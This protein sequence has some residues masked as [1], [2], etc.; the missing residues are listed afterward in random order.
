MHNQLKGILAGAYIL[1]IVLLLL[2]TCRHHR[3]NPDEVG[4]DGDIKITMFWDFPGDVDLHV[5]QPNGN[6]L[7]F[8]NMDDS[9][10]RGG[11]LDV[12]DRTGG[13]GS[14][15]N[16]YWRDPMEG[17]YRVRVVYYRADDEAPDGGPV[18][19][20]V[21]INGRSTE[22]NIELHNA[23]DDIPV[24]TFNYSRRVTATRPGQ[25]DTAQ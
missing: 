24:T 23:Q 10:N 18:R 16:A 22:Y 7:S 2:T 1:L 5:D 20:V 19:V 8:M 4:E 6:E 12:D 3:G 25:N 17:R 9:A 21:K 15:E 14:A 13:R 11:V